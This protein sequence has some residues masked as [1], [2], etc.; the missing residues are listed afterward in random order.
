[1]KLKT[2]MLLFVLVAFTGSVAT[3]SAECSG[4]KDKKKK[5]EETK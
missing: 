5:E 3:V 1:M 4:C 2:L